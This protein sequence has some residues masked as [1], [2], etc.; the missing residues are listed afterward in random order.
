MVFIGISKA[1][2]VEQALGKRPVY[3]LE[4]EPALATKHKYQPM[5]QLYLITPKNPPQTN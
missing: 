5:G 2:I 4:F 3:D 1:A